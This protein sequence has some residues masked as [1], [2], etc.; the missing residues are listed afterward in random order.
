MLTTVLLLEQN[1]QNFIKTKELAEDEEG[2]KLFEKLEK[3]EFEHYQMLLDEYNNMNLN[4]GKAII[5]NHFKGG[6]L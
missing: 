1:S 6:I 4:S 5:F 3:W 2:K